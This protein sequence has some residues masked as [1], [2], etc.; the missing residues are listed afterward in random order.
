VLFGKLIVQRRGMSGKIVDCS[1]NQ[2]TNNFMDDILI[3]V[4][5]SEVIFAIEQYYGFPEYD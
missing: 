5:A 4:K 1:H 3:E 2:T